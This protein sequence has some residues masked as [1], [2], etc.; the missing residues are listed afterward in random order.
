MGFFQAHPS[1]IYSSL[2]VYAN[3]EIIVPRQDPAPSYAVDLGLIIL[4]NFLDFSIVWRTLANREATNSDISISETVPTIYL[5]KFE[6]PIG[7]VLVASE[8]DCAPV[9]LTGLTVQ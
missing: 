2:V 3:K 1:T 7:F 6:D 4:H 5:V 9:F 8:P